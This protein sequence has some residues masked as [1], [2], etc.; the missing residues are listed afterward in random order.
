MLQIPVHPASRG[1][2][3]PPPGSLTGGMWQGPCHRPIDTGARAHTAH[4]WCRRAMCCQH[5]R[6][7][8]CS[9]VGRETGRGQLL[10]CI[11]RLLIVIF[12]GIPMQRPIHIG[13]PWE[14][15]DSGVGA[16]VWRFLIHG[17][18]PRDCLDWGGRGKFGSVFT[19]C[20]RRC[21]GSSRAGRR[22]YCG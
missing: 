19:V 8:K 21:G 9:T 6:I 20:W 11:V 14:C 16:H 10:F 5:R 2:V 4:T 7:M 22:G 3:V 1:V 12:W 18:L 13:L 15:L 17:G